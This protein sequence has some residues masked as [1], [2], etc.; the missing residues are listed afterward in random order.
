MVDLTLSALHSLEKSL[1][2]MRGVI[3]EVITC[4][5]PSYSHVAARVSPKSSDSSLKVSIHTFE[6]PVQAKIDA[7]GSRSSSSSP[8]CFKYG[9]AGYFASVCRNAMLCFACN[10]F[11]HKSFHCKQYR[12]KQNSPPAPPS[13]APPKPIIHEQRTNPSL[14]PP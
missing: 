6:N 8:Q 14:T 2:E 13:L 12:V 11:G 5:K 7:L 3:R 4:V 1:L 10:S 9:E